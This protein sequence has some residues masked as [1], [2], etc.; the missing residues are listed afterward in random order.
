LVAELGEFGGEKRDGVRTEAMVAAATVVE[1]A[2]E[3]VGLERAGFELHAGQREHGLEQLLRSVDG[4]GFAS[5]VTHY[6]GIGC[7][8]EDALAGVDVSGDVRIAVGLPLNA[9]EQEQKAWVG[10]E[11][12]AS[13]FGGSVLAVEGVVIAAKSFRFDEMRLLRGVYARE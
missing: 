9:R 2:A 13:G 11:N 5:P 12:A 6:A 1:I 10:A 3:Q 8:V 4:L 7:L